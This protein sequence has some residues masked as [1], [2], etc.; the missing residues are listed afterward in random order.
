MSAARQLAS[1]IE[2][3]WILNPVPLRT[4]GPFR[5]YSRAERQAV[6]VETVS[7]LVQ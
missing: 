7:S 4:A 6:T 2:T 3:R 1:A 5:L